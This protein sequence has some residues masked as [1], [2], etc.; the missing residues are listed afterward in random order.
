M[1][2]ADNLG[3]TLKGAAKVLLLSRISA[4]RGAGSVPDKDARLI[5]LG[6][7][8]SLREV[9]D[10]YGAELGKEHCLAVNFALSSPEIVAVRPEYYV[11]ADP[12]FFRAK[13]ED[14]NVD[15]LWDNIAAADW[16]MT[17]YVPAKYGRAARARLCGCGNVRVSTFNAV[18]V[19]GFAW[20]RRAVYAPGL[21]MPRP[22][23]VLIPSIM[24]AIRE[25]FRNIVL[26]GADH[27]WMSTLAVSDDNE[28]V[29]VQPHFYKEDSRE[30]ARVR[31]EYRG[32][33]LHTIVESF[34]VAFR[35]YHQIQDFAQSRG[36]KI[37]NCTKGSFIDAF[38][39]RPIGQIL[40]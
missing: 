7:G 5:I 9:L 25:G 39:R 18:G 14:T 13:G 21:G 2:F 20:F 22:R 12:H 28:V 6:N 31:H 36:V 8:P 35:A 26:L 34:A 30:E 15:R 37:L 16:R 11:L 17:L 27:S 19:E 1:K 24:L 29:S 33:R 38:E 23:N 3:A 4:C 10:E 32:Y 40:R